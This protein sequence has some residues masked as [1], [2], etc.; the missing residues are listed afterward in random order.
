MDLIL[1]GGPTGIKLLVTNEIL[2]A[3]GANRF[4]SRDSGETW[5]NLGFDRDSFV[6]NSLP[7]VS[8][9]ENTFYRAGLFGIQR[10]TDGGTSWHSFMD[11]IVGTNIKD[12]VAFNNRLYVRTGNNL[13]VSSDSGKT[14]KSVRVNA[15]EHALEPTERELPGVNFSFNSKL[16]VAAGKLYGILPEE[17][18]LR[19]F[20]LHKDDNILS[21]VQGIP[22]FDQEV[23]PTELMTAIAEAE[24]IDLIDD[25]KRSDQLANS[26]RHIV[27]Q[28]K[29]GGFAVNG[30][31]FYVEH[32][33]MLFKWKLGETEWTHTGL[34]DLGK[35]P[36]ADLLNAF[37]VAT[38][39]EI[40][41]VGKRDGKV[42]SIL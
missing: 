29:A 13:G 38:S 21:P 26:L 37:K 9:N 20:S 24:R 33:R 40:V 11:G 2:L 31:T 3:Q 27:A 5:T 4:L 17:H 6:L 10:T 32:R 8:V 36:S 22:S 16:A 15:K 12:L 34:I 18:N 19:F 1:W 41:Y 35:P 30:E 28:A 23:L 42:V 7:L 25:P 14:W 39:A